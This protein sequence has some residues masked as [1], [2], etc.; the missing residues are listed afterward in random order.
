MKLFPESAVSNDFDSQVG[1][2]T[3][4]VPELIANPMVNARVSGDPESCI[5]F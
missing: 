3:C 2:A 4:P 1:L 5:L